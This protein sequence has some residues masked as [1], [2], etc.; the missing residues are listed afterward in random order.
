M[1]PER[2]K[3]YILMATVDGIL[4]LGIALVAIF[5]F[6]PLYPTAPALAF[7]AVVFNYAVM[8]LKRGVLARKEVTTAAKAAPKSGLSAIA[9][10]YTPITPTSSFTESALFWS[11][12]FS[13][14]VSLISMI[15]SIPFDP[16]LQGTPT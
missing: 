3:V 4:F 10:D 5:R 6:V 14:A 8:F 13:S 15:C 12:A 11:A 1:T 2:K 9:P 16:S 7:V